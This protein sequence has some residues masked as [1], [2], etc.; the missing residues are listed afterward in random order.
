MNQVGLGVDVDER[1]IPNSNRAAGRYEAPAAIAKR[2]DVLVE[3][4]VRVN[5]VRLVN[6]AV[7]AVWAGSH[8]HQERNRPVGIK[9]EF[10]PDAN[11]KRG[12]PGRFGHNPSNLVPVVLPV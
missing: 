4:Y 8:Q 9:V 2:V 10:A 11:S 7:L 6:D 12:G 5:P 1:V 3:P